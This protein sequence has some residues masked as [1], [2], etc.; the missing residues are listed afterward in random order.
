[1]I[2][3]GTRIRITHLWDPCATDDA[4][5]RLVLVGETGVITENDPHRLPQD[6]NPW[7]CWLVRL[8]KGGRQTYLCRDEIEREDRAENNRSG[9][10]G[11]YISPGWVDTAA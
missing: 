7:D 5:G 4:V 1:M 11:E 3:V 10:N 2:R 8:D 6:H 9:K